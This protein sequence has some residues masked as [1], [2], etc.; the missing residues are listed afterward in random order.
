MSPFDFVNA[1]NTTKED[2]IRGSANP[3]LAENLYKP[4]LI[5]KAFSYF[6]DTVMYANEINMF[7]NTEH[8]LQN[9]YYLNSIRKNKRFSKWHKKE[10]EPKIEAIMEYY[11]VNYIKARE[12]GNVLTDEQVDHIIRKL[13]KGGNN[14]QS[15]SVGGG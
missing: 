1:I 10:D 13:I 2:L 5:N 7:P 15:R 4:Y 3:D 6:K 12:I 8:K 9:D 14:V 11:N